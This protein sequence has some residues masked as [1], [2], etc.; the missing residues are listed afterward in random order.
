MTLLELG[1]VVA[2]V[3]LLAA[4]MRLA[5][6]LQRLTVAAHELRD[7]ASEHLEYFTEY[8][9]LVRLHWSIKHPHEHPPFVV[10]GPPPPPPGPRP[11][12]PPV[13]PRDRA[14]SAT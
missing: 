12:T 8:E 1:L 14:V 3:A 9:R 13:P 11:A 5:Y 4:V 6:R 7:A 10:L 2:V